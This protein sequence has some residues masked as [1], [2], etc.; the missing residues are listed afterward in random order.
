MP[1]RIRQ[2]MHSHGHRQ[3]VWQFAG[4]LCLRTGSSSRRCAETHA[5]PWQCLLWLYM[6]AH[7]AIDDGLLGRCA[8]DG[9]GCQT[10]EH[11]VGLHSK[12]HGRIDTLL[13]AGFA[14]PSDLPLRAGCRARPSMQVLSSIFG[15][16]SSNVA[17]RSGRI[18][19]GFSVLQAQYLDVFRMGRTSFGLRCF[20]ETLLL[21]PVRHM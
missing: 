3:L 11:F 19:Y 16:R 6:P 4:F 18:G 17:C 8:G 2:G 21:A 9:S 20:C 13:Y 10:L 12:L 5:D 1:E 15:Y 14:G 7:V